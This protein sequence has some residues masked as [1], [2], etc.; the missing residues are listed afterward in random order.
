MLAEVDAYHQ[1]AGVVLPEPGYDPQ[2][3]LLVNSWPVLVRQLW[4]VLLPV[5]LLVLGVPLLLLWWL[6]RRRRAGIGQAV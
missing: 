3:Q 1:R 6:R 2:R 4:F 5:A